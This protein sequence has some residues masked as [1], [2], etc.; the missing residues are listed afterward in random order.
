MTAPASFEYHSLTIQLPK[1]IWD[2]L[3]RDSSI[4][5]R[6]SVTRIVTQVLAEHYRIERT[7]LPKRKRP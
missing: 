4:G 6:K 1:V 7:Q 5:S 3:R 2:A